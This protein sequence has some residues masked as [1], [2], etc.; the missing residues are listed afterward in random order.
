[1]KDV[2]KGVTI[3]IVSIIVVIILVGG[4]SYFAYKHFTG[5]VKNSMEH[6]VVNTVEVIKEKLESAAELNTVTYLCT[7]VITRTDSREFKDWKIPFTEKSFIVQYDGIVKAGIRDLSEAQITQDRETIII[8]LPA[9]EITGVEIDNESFE[10][11]DESN[12]IF[13][14]ISIEDLNDAQN[15]L[16]GKMKESATEKGILDIAKSNAETVLFEMLS[17]FNGEY[18][19]KIEWSQE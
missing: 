13:N 11:L 17:S 6:E 16:K 12:S 8:K 19:V 9:V 10:K 18:E 2:L 5:Q 7:D 15:D 14:P 4:G 3:K 1:M